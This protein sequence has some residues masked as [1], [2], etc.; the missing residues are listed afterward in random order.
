LKIE[1]YTLVFSKFIYNVL[2]YQLPHWP[3]GSVPDC[4]VLVLIGQKLQASDW[5][6]T[7]AGQ[8]GGPLGLQLSTSV[9]KDSLL[10]PLS[11]Y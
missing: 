5:L 6:V 1:L 9:G 8:V 4:L 7:L 3:T 2:N 10:S 11:L